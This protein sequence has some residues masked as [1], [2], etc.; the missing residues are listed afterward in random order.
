VPL[1]MPSAL[2]PL[3][4][5]MYMIRVLSSCPMSSTAWMTRPI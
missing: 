4:P 1:S 5:L 2:A 3:S